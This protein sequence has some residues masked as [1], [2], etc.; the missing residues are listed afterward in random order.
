M[1]GKHQLKIVS[2][3]QTGVDRAA[4]DFA[5]A[6]SIPHGGWCPKGRRAED[7]RIPLPYQLQE[8]DA[9]DYAVRTEQNVIDSDA[10]LILFRDKVSGGTRLT[11]YLA[12]KHARPQMRI[13]L[14]Q[15][16]S[17]EQLEIA[18]VSVSKWLGE[19]Q[20]RTLNIAG[21]R[22]SSNPG[23]HRQALEFLSAVLGQFGEY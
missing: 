14:Q 13:D 11:Q 9:R 2:G 23:I 10:T 7:G 20:I 17:P 6:A 15:A 1:V 18:T 8:S 19:H 21:P 22:E 4:L 12:S 3:G 5:I 16:D